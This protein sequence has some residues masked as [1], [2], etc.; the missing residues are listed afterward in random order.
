MCQRTKRPG[1]TQILK[2]LLK[3]QNLNV[4]VKEGEALQFLVER[5]V[6]WKTKVIRYL[7]KNQ[8]FQEYARTSTFKYRLIFIEIL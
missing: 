8:K 5:A 1:L 7:Q 2:L 4:R 3:L 6:R